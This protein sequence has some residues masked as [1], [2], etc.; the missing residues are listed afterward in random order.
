MP[1]V[2][3]TIENNRPLLKIKI[4]GHDPKFYSELNATVDTGFSDFLLLPIQEAFTAALILVGIRN[5]SLADASN[6]PH[7]LCLGTISL[8]GKETVGQIAV[9]SSWN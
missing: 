9:S 3:G 2:I 8:A 7:L 4:W 1:R 5:Y 6:V